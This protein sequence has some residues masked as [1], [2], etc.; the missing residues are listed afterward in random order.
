MIGL[1]TLLMCVVKGKAGYEICLYLLNKFRGDK[2]SNTIISII[3]A[4]LL[5]LGLGQLFIEYY[6]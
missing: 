5:A 6:H 4:V 1:F 2:Q 3:L